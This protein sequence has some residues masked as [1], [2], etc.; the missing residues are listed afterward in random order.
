[1]ITFVFYVIRL[2]Y[3][4]LMYFILIKVYVSYKN[5]CFVLFMLFKFILCFYYQNFLCLWDQI[6]DSH[7]CDTLF[8]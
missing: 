7:I 8:V 5:Q 3:D 2:F 4:H 6:G 1:V